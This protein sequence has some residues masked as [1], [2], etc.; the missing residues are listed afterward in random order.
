MTR[1]N[2]P[3]IARTNSQ[4]LNQP[5]L[6]NDDSSI[7]S[8]SLL[9]KLRAAL[10]RD[11]DF[12]ASAKV[13]TELR[14]LVSDPRT[15]AHQITE[16]IL[17]EPS[18]G[19]RVLSL[20][21]SSFYRR[22]KPIMTVSQAVIQVGM[23]PLAELCSGL[24]LLQKF[25]P[26]ARKGGIFAHCL[27]KSICTALLS[28]S[29]GSQVQSRGES[30]DELGYLAGSF[31]ELGT[32]LLAF[33]F[34]NIYESAVRRAKQKS[35]D[36]SQGIREITGLS[37]L[38]LS[39]EVISALNLPDFYKEVLVAANSIDDKTELVLATGRE[40]IAHAARS[41][42]AA[43]KISEAV[44]FSS[45]QK[46]LEIAMQKVKNSLG[47]DP[48]ELNKIVGELPKRFRDHCSTIEVSLASLPEFVTNYSK[49]ESGS[50]AAASV[51]AESNP[52]AFN[53]FVEEVRAAVEN[54]EPTSSV[55]TTVMESL[56]WGFKFE[57]VLLM[58]LTANKTKLTGR[59]L[60]G[61]AGIDPKSI[62]RTLSEYP[63][64]PDVI[65]FNEGRAIFA[66]E[67]VLRNGWPL[68]AIPVGIKQKAIGVIYADRLN[69]DIE[70]SE[71][72]RAAIVVLAELLDR[73]L[74]AS[75]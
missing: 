56:A 49:A 74:S 47:L 19:T 54:R 1:E 64:A 75:S 68:A 71:R 3:N 41:I 52:D 30:S 66:G 34:P 12:P 65:A 14:R 13:V 11:G 51:T 44:V 63:Y 25:V 6:S 2:D 4:A 9:E 16:V 61:G 69:Q 21:N 18:L 43:E 31:A 58:L 40:N 59:M 70:L 24:I 60:L 7:S 10:Q 62:S 27:Q 17:K 26:A 39:M 72:E 23:K 55:I 33:Y 67:S 73:S 8:E 50:T 48:K 35:C 20:V 38:T 5:A 32:L 46:A 15:T 29:L 22:A 53:Q 45:D 36:I 28:G 57:R 37:P 42:N